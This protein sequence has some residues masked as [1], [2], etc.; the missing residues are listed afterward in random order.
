MGIQV[1]HPVPIHLNPLNGFVVAF[2][3]PIWPSFPQPSQHSS[4]GPWW[5]Q[6]CLPP[7]AAHRAGCTQ[8]LQGC[9]GAGGHPG[10]PQP[11]HGS[12][13]L[14]GKRQGEESIG[15]QHPKEGR[16]W[17]GA[18][19]EGGDRAGD[20][21]AGPEEG[22][23]VG[24]AGWVLP[25]PQAEP[26]A[27]SG[28]ALASPLSPCCHRAGAGPAEPRGEGEPQGAGDGQAWG[29]GLR[30]KGP[31]P[32][33]GMGW[34][35]C[36]GW[37]GDSLAVPK[38]PPASR[39]PQGEVSGQESR[40]G[41][42]SPGVIRPRER[43]KLP[44]FSSK[45]AGR[46][47]DITLHPPH[48]RLS[49]RSYINKPLSGHDVPIPRSLRPSRPPPAACPSPSPWAVTQPSPRTHSCAL[50]PEHRAP[51]TCSPRSPCPQSHRQQRCQSAGGGASGS[52]GR[53]GYGPRRR[54]QG[55]AWESAGSR[56]EAC[57]EQ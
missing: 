20:Q 37:Q 9:A 2:F 29:Q 42:R 15:G 50:L 24:G 10:S 56:K 27:P 26:P 54:G 31:C 18:G 13:T 36:G 40:A 33:L 21:R 8:Q 6:R 11:C 22:P 39:E 25:S 43:G 3:S 51:P 53:P 47:G 48:P 55:D 45:P 49:C 17:R 28:D 34:R 35:G 30:G 12:G 16:A 1:F 7:P 41:H 23:A 44:H 32:A 52:L 14:A 57:A 5:T 46:N 38:S 4:A 19:Q